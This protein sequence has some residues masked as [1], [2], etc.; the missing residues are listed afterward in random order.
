M[1]RPKAVIFDFGGV[2]IT[3]PFKAIED[4]EAQNDI[5]AGYLNYAMSALHKTILT[6]DPLPRRIPGLNSKRVYYEQMRH[7]IDDGPQIYPHKRRGKASIELGDY[8]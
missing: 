5:P 3:S 2:L 7:S 1:L 6:V 8:Q 4:Y